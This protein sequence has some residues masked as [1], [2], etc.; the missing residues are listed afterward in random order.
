M[1]AYKY[2]VS[3]DELFRGLYTQTHYYI[4]GKC[5]FGV[6]TF[7]DI[8]FYRDDA[9]S[10]EHAQKIVDGTVQCAMPAQE[11][12]IPDDLV[13]AILPLGKRLKQVESAMRDLK[14]SEKEVKSELEGVLTKLYS[15]K[16][17]LEN[18]RYSM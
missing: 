17:V 9:G 12:E 15:D 6:K 4:P 1:K 18:S 2:G 11:I 3:A 5:L 14:T 8:D 10:L 7:E 13:A 16:T